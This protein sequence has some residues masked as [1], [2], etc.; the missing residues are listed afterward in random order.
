MLGSNVNVLV[1]KLT[2]ETF[3][4]LFSIDFYLTVKIGKLLGTILVGCLTIVSSTIQKVS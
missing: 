2:Q 4:A 1:K 3:F